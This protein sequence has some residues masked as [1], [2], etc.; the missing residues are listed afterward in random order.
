MS[1]FHLR[2]SLAHQFQNSSIFIDY[3]FFKIGFISYIVAIAIKNYLLTLFNNK[4]LE[5]T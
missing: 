2:V 4:E 5:E 1:I 3:I